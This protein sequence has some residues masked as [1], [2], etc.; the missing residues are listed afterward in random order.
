[1]AAAVSGLSCAPA[2]PAASGYVR[3]FGHG[4][5]RNRLAPKPPATGSDGNPGTDDAEL[6]TLDRRQRRECGR[7]AD[8]DEPV[9][10][11]GGS[12][13]GAAGRQRLT[14]P[15]DLTDTDEAVAGLVCDPQCST[16]EGEPLRITAGGH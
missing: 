5:T 8:E 3:S 9:V 11:A 16:P 13:L 1:M 10:V 7:C 14:R 15:G 12:R 2:G 4:S 6:L